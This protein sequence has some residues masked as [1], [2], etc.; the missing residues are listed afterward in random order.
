MKDHSSV[1]PQRLN[2]FPRG[3]R[4]PQGIPVELSPTKGEWI[5]HESITLIWREVLADGRQ[6]VVKLYK[7]GL[8]VW[9]R[10]LA[11]GF[12][13]Q[14]EFKGLSQLETLGI[15]CS[16]PLFWCHGH[17]GPYG[18]GEIL[19][20]ERVVR[21]QALR[22]L[23][24]TRPEVRRFLD[25]SPFF[26]D[27]ARMHAAGLYHGTLKPRNILVKNYPERPAFVLIDMP[28]FHRF[29]WDIRGTRMARYDLMSLCDGLLRFFPDDTVPLWLSAYGIP[30]S[31]RMDLLVRIKRF[32]ST[33]FLRRVFGA[34]FRLRMAIAKSFTF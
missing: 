15:A 17:F 19:A 34:E 11:T 14:R 10:S 28:R 27:V 1:A 16:V 18:W 30:E 26:A 4:L 2:V 5:K 21:S 32:R 9:C 23:L 3:G 13:V 33:M 24:V 29:P 20:T 31:E 25:L 12:R 22:D 6:V 8:P 7:R